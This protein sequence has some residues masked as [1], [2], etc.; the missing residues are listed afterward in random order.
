MINRMTVRVIDHEQGGI[1]FQIIEQNI[2][3]TVEQI[4]LLLRRKPFRRL[5]ATCLLR[6]GYVTIGASRKGSKE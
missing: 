2:P 1:I 6:N 4:E 3:A 5:V